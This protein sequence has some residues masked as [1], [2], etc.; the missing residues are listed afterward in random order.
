MW[1]CAAFVQ[2]HVITTSG[3][4]FVLDTQSNG[5]LEYRTVSLMYMFSVE[6][7]NDGNLGLPGRVFRQRLPEWTA[8]VEYYNCKEYPRLNY[9]LHYNKT[10]FGPEVDKVCKALEAV[11]L[12]SSEL[13]DHPSF[14]ICNGVRQNALVEI[15]Q[16][17]T[18]VC[19]THKL[20]LVQTWVPCK[21]RRVLANDGGGVKKSCRSFDGSWSPYPSS[22]ASLFLGVGETTPDMMF[23]KTSKVEFRPCQ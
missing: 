23:G 19:E 1:F 14:E 17:L 13:L 11:N 8:D 7:E 20:A 4:P 5:L 22:V 21:H 6:G 3:Q 16:I 10:N 12:K 9:A 15:F 2:K 18:M